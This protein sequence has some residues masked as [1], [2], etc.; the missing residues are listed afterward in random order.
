M[1]LYLSVIKPGSYTRR[2]STICRVVQQNE[3]NKCLVPFKRRVSKLFTL[4]N[5]KMVPYIKENK[6]IIDIS[7]RMLLESI[8]Y[9]V[10]ATF[11]V[12]QLIHL[13]SEW[14]PYTVIN[15]FAYNHTIEFVNNS[16]GTCI[17]PWTCEH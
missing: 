12:F 14:H 1:V 4:I 11:V 6:L 3:G 15:V 10:F 8:V 17:L 13:V 7:F 5:V 2:G 16:T 9:S